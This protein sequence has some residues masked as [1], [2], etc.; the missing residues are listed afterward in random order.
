MKV[1]LALILVLGLTACRTVRVV[2]SPV[3]A[4]SPD[5]TGSATSRQAVESFFAAMKSGDLQAASTVWGSKSGASRD[6]MPR[7]Q[8]ESRLLIIQ[9]WLAHDT[10]RIINMPR[11]AKADSAFYRVE[12]TK[13]G[14]AQ[15]TDVITVT[16]PRQRW[17]VADPKIV[18]LTAPGCRT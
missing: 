15:Q 1:V 16:G 4:T 7:D 17:Y 10:M 8:M 12:L 14:R 6:Y 5:M 18:G 3:V 13:T 9:C 11:P 2:E